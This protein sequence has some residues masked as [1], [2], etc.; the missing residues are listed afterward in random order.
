MKG[1]L[2]KKKNVELHLFKNVPRYNFTFK[3]Y[4]QKIFGDS[5][6]EELSKDCIEKLM[7]KVAWRL[8]ASLCIIYFQF[9]RKQV[10]HFTVNDI[11]SNILS[12]GKPMEDNKLH[13]KWQWATYEVQP[14]F[15]TYGVLSFHYWIPWMSN[16]DFYLHAT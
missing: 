13:C 15:W 8:N 12:E 4:E 11:I 2:F 10:W 16:L 14:V 1:L 6:T 9:S 5:K 3:S 7:K